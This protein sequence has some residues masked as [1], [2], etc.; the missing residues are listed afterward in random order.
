MGCMT[1]SNGNIFRI[2]GPLWREALMFSLICPWTKH[3]ADK[4]DASDLRCYHVHY[5]VIEMLEVTHCICRGNNTNLNYC[6]PYISSTV[7][8][9]S[10]FPPV[11]SLHV[12]NALTPSLSF[13]CCLSRS[14]L[15]TCSLALSPSFLCYL[16]CTLSSSFLVAHSHS[17][18]SCHSW[19]PSLSA[20]PYSPAASKVTWQKYPP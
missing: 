10:L 5:D 20:C 8:S 4:W 13:A 16:I 6:L 9:L 19:S 15:P 1:L 3:W 18:F 14:F 7:L 17:H 2:T 12:S 11:L